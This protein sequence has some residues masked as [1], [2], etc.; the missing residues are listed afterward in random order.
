MESRKMGIDEPFAGQGRD[1][2]QIYGL[3]P[4]LMGGKKR[5]E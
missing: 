4:L 1:R 2:E 5:V 3:F